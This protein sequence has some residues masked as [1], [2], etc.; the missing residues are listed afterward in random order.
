MTT[1]RLVDSGSDATELERRLLAASTDPKPRQSD[2][3]AVWQRLMLGLADA[4][5]A[6]PANLTDESLPAPS[7]AP[8][9]SPSLGPPL[10]WAPLVLSGVVGLAVGV[11]ATTSF[12]LLR[13][14]ASPA[15]PTAPVSSVIGSAPAASVEQRATGTPVRDSVEPRGAESLP[16]VEVEPMLPPTRPQAPPGPQAAA[17]APLDGATSRLRQE[18]A[19]LRRAREQLG[20]GALTEAS[21]TLTESRLAFPE[22]RLSQ[23]REAL[24]IEL[25]VRQGRTLEARTLARVFLSKHPQSPHAPQV[26]RALETPSQD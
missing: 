14:D 12:F 16:S 6:D 17:S 1:K 21:N 15:R 19:L 25:Y 22:S 7:P 5:E 4:P 9:P 24:T 18:A 13:D 2:R 3:A 23:E 10:P 11:V 8:S 20:R 26:R